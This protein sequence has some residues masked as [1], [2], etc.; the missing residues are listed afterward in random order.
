MD[1][2]VTQYR[3]DTAGRSVTGPLPVQIPFPDFGSSV[4]FVSELTAES[5]APSLDFSYK[6]ETRW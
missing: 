1:Q 3:K 4:F 6:R 2:L 5:R